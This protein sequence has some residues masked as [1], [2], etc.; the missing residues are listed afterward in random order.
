MDEVSTTSTVS[1]DADTQPTNVLFV[2]NLSWGV[3]DAELAEFFTDE[4]AGYAPQADETGAPMAKVILDRERGNRSKGFGFVTFVDAETAQKA[5]EAKQGQPLLDREV[6]IQYKTPREE[7]PRRS[8]DR[9]DRPRRDFGDRGGDRRPRRSYD[10]NN[11]N[12]M[13]A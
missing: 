4:E 11:Y 9:G 10:D 1:N 7:R 12:R 13:A 8:F 6:R 3:G 5:M 2:G